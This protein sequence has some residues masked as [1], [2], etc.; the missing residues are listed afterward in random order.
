V[1]ILVTGSRDWNDRLAVYRA[2][3]EVCD[4]HDL[5]HIPDEYGNTMPDPRRVT[6]VH[7]HCPTGA[8][9]WADQWCIGNFFGAER[10]PADWG[11]YGRKAGPLRNAHM[12]SLG[13]DICL[14]FIG[15]CTSPRCN[16][17]GKHPSHG[18]TGCA[19]LAERA[20]IPVR[21]FLA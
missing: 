8:D 2:L 12:V 20:D 1:R 14:A 10:H 18:A 6:V 4:E 15:P 17:E 9:H 5:N 13:A 21:R 7:G 3:I 19:D 16:I 11:Q